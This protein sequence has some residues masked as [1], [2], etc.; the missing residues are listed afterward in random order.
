M[1]PTERE[2]HYTVS[3]VGKRTPKRVLGAF[4]YLRLA[5]AQESERER[6]EGVREGGRRVER[7]GKEGGREGG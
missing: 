7:G 1:G 5:T 4:P 6:E 3:L 2:W